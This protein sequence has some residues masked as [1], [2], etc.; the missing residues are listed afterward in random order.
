MRRTF[1]HLALFLAAAAATA[2]TEGVAEF[3]VIRKG[4]TRE[5]GTSITGTMYF[6]R[7]AFRLESMGQTPT[8]ARD[9]KDGASAE[10]DRKSVV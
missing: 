4:G 5:H 9:E 6:S 1:L 8:A 7:T 3:H 10:R 2:Q